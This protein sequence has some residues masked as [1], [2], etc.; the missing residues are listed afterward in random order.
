MESFDIWKYIHIALRRKWWIIIPFLIVLLGGLAHGLTA[1]QAYEAKTLILVQPQKVPTEFIRSIVSTNIDDRLK[2]IGQQV[3]SRTNLESIIKNFQLYSNSNMLL[4]E[5]VVLVREK[6]KIEVVIGGKDSGG[7]AFSISFRDKDPRKVM[8][9]TNSLASNFISENLK[10]R[11]S[12]A[13]GTSTF[14]SDELESIRRRLAKKEKG[15]QAFRSKFMGALPDQLQTNLNILD[16]L[17]MQIEQLNNSLRDAE[18]RKLIIQKQ[19]SD[20]ETMRKQMA[21]GMGE[22]AIVEFEESSP[23]EEGGYEESA[24][25]KKQLALLKSRYKDSHPDIIRLKK[26]LQKMKKEEEAQ[27]TEAAE[28]GDETVGPESGSI[29]AESLIPSMDDFLKPQL[30]QVNIEIN[31]IKSEIN[32]AQSKMENYQQRVEETPAREQELLGLSRDYENL[33]DLYESMLNRKLEADIAVSMEKKQKGEQFRVIDPAKIPNR[34]A[35]PDL[36]AIFIITLVLGMGLGCGLAYLVEFL[37]TSLKTPEEA[38]RELQLT[39]LV[40]MPIQYTAK[41]RKRLRLKKFAE[42]A[43]VAAGFVFAAIGI[44]LATKGVSSAINFIKGIIS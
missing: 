37:D 30:E 20:A 23:G 32:K 1:P 13:L 31:N 5:K 29:G 9:V 40:K 21:E 16:R 22:S 12:Q 33:R 27:E 19:I 38:E 24:K 36:K 15:V 3:T 11:E 41:E 4:E 26:L 28:P 43:S 44:V 17:Q 39:V 35:E 42:I 10:I 8:Q 6:I 18:N 25:L 7:N 2:T 14:L 34:P